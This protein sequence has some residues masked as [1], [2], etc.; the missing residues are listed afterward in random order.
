MTSTNQS[1][2]GRTALVTGATSGIGRAAANWRSGRCP[3]DP[4]VDGSEGGGELGVAVSDQEPEGVPG[5]SACGVGGSRVAHADGCD[6][7]KPVMLGDG[8]CVA[9]DRR[10][11]D[12]Y[13]FGSTRQ[14]RDPAQKSQDIGVVT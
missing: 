6:C 4:H 5:R 1:L 9:R 8:R 10:G 12:L 13:R 7:G 3:D 14:A 2:R 11:Q